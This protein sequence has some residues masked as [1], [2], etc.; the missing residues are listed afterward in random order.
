[1]HALQEGKRVP[2]GT[3]PLCGYRACSACHQVPMCGRCATHPPPADSPLQVPDS[4][5]GAAQLRR[6]AQQPWWVGQAGS[7]PDGHRLPPAAMRPGASRSPTWSP[8]PPGRLITFSLRSHAGACWLTQ[9]PTAA[10]RLPE[11][12]RCPGTALDAARCSTGQTDTQEHAPVPPPAGVLYR[13]QGNMERAV[14]CYQAALNARPNFPQASAL[15]V[16]WEPLS[17]TRMERQ[18]SCMCSA[19]GRRPRPAQSCSLEAWKP[20][21]CGRTARTTPLAAPAL[22]AAFPT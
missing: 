20:C 1:M 21:P 14:Q 12:Q 15:G 17:C 3:V 7:G 10:T 16:R 19:H 2:A 9:L 13:E 6:G 4:A 5:V 22:L 11:R 18:G 8:R